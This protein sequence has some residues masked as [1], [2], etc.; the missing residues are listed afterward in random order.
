MDKYGYYILFLSQFIQST[1][2]SYEARVTPYSVRIIA[3]IQSAS[4]AQIA[5]PRNCFEQNPMWGDNNDIPSSL[6]I[7]IIND[8]CL[9]FAG[10]ITSVKK[11]VFAGTIMQHPQLDSERPAE[12]MFE[13]TSFVDKGMN[14]SASNFNR[15]GSLMTDNGIQIIKSLLQEQERSTYNLSMQS[16]FTAG[17]TEILQNS[18][19]GVNYTPT[20]TL[21]SIRANLLRNNGIFMSTTYDYEFTTQKIIVNNNFER[22]LTDSTSPFLKITCNER[23]SEFTRFAIQNKGTDKVPSSRQ[24]FYARATKDGRVGVSSDVYFNFSGENGYDEFKKPPLMIAHSFTSEKWKDMEKS[25]SKTPSSPQS[26]IYLQSIKD[27][28]NKYALMQTIKDSFMSQQLRI[29]IPSTLIVKEQYFTKDGTVQ[30]N[31]S[32]IWSVGDKVII[33]I[34]EYNII[35]ARM[36]ITAYDAFIDDRRG[37]Q[38]ELTL[39]AD[40]AYSMVDHDMFTLPN[41]VKVALGVI[42][43]KAAGVYYTSFKPGRIDLTSPTN[44]NAFL[45]ARSELVSSV[46]EQIKRF[47]HQPEFQ[48]QLLLLKPYANKINDNYYSML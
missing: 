13:C 43:A 9:I 47:P 16:K 34:P 48:K 8:S 5:I 19:I 1:G 15:N 36:L 27:C 45:N 22:S 46:F 41:A 4:V 31:N 44:I 32:K 6:Y 25:I 40:I 3:G 23:G 12:I 29:T 30:Y 17:A 10:D 24:Y 35:E 7:P 33:T 28:L 2:R 39:G 26:K 42:N 37:I 38:I 20:D 14:K 11:L 21:A 18:K